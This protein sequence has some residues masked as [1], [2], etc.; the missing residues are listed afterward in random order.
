MREA[1]KMGL[2]QKAVAQHF[3]VSV[4]TVSDVVNER[5][6]MPEPTAAARSPSVTSHSAA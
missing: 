6:W 3:G 4:G 2:S 1:V 5:R